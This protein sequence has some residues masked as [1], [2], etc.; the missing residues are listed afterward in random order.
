MITKYLTVDELLQLA[1]DMSK[2]ADFMRSGIEQETAK[3]VA[4]HLETQA[5]V[6]LLMSTNDMV[7]IC[8]ARGEI[9]MEPPPRP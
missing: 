8:A 6:A 1:D 9:P 4:F 7:V 2:R 3:A 5:M